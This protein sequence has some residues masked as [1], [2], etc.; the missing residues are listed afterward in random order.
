MGGSEYSRH[1][2]GIRKLMKNYL[3]EVGV[4]GWIWTGYSLSVHGSFG[5]LQGNILIPIHCVW[6]RA[7]WPL[8]LGAHFLLIVWGG[9]Q[10]ELC[11]VTL[12]GL[13]LHDID[14]L[15]YFINHHI[16]L[17]WLLLE[18]FEA[19]TNGCHFVDGIMNTSSSEKCLGFWLKLISA[20]KKYR[21]QGVNISYNFVNFIWKS[22][23]I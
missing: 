23:K 20:N 6:T 12:L 11:P 22:E 7:I 3:E 13:T 4:N 8:S 9:L 10:W 2:L 19:K 14:V 21:I 16:H 18:I 5:I 17:H 1:V 15:W